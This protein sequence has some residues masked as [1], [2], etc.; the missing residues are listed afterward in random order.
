MKVG[1]CIHAKTHAEFLNQILRKDYKAWMKSCYH[2][3]DGKMIWMIQLGD[4]ISKTGWINKL[5]TPKEIREKHVHLIFDHQHN[6]Y[7]NA[8]QTGQYFNCS[9]RVVFDVIKNKRDRVYVFRGVF[10]LN[11]QESS[12]NENV[13]DLIKDEYIIY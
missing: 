1:Y 2:L 7:K 6:T 8:L 9:D 13:W 10:R 12:S 3:S 11:K 4:F 5:A